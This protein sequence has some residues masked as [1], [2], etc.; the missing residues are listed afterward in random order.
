MI[1]IRLKT[2]RRQ[3]V[4]GSAEH[5]GFMRDCDCDEP[6]GGTSFNNIIIDINVGTVK[7]QD[8]DGRVKGHEKERKVNSH[9]INNRAK[10][11]TKGYEK[12]GKGKGKGHG[13]DRRTKPYD[14][15]GGAKV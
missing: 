12:D 11:R 1:I 15:D 6:G 9:G 13:L 14:N 3:C 7:S 4:C 5:S 8:K 10:R 2:P